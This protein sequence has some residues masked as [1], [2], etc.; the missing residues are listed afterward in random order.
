MYMVARE[1][2]IV[3]PRKAICSD[4]VWVR[5]VEDDDPWGDDWYPVNIKD[6]RPLDA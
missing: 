2:V 1:R 5:R 3:T 4:V 6:L